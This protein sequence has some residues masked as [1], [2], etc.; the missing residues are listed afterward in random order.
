MVWCISDRGHFF[1]LLFLLR[2]RKIYS[3][4]LS[5]SEAHK[6][7]W[8][9]T[10][11][12]PRLPFRTSDLRKWLKPIARY[13]RLD[14]FDQRSASLVISD[15]GIL[16]FDFPPGTFIWCCPLGLSRISC[17]G[18]YVTTTLTLRLL[19]T[20]RK[21][22]AKETTSYVVFTSTNVQLFHQS[23]LGTTQHNETTASII[24]LITLH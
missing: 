16:S 10:P 7:S 20:F 15:R 21:C 3:S 17:S 12:L 6:K 18:T 13:M 1:W 24:S 23:T 19:F 9:G 5:C 14:R 22:G 2:F 8:S 4:F 11:G